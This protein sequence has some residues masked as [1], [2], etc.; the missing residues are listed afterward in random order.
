M[1]ELPYKEN[2]IS[3]TQSIREFTSDVH[4]DELKWH[5]D[6]EDRTIVPLIEN[7]WKFQFDNRLPIDIKE[8]IIIKKG[9]WH[10][11]IKGKGDLRLLIIR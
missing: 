6:N 4:D 3:E 2:W 8:K 11:L 5:F 9:E 10:R 7:D 1:E